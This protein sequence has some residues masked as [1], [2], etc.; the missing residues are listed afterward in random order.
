MVVVGETILTS[1]RRAPRG[2]M[3]EVSG[4]DLG[5]GKGEDTGHLSL[6]DKLSP[7]LWPRPGAWEAGLGG[8]GRLQSAVRGQR[9]KSE[10]GSWAGAGQAHSLAP[11][12]KGNGCWVLRKNEVGS[13]FGLKT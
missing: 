13:E 3:V 10:A 5:K 9:N 2:Q 12:A 6:P 8:G 4:S 1:E 11:G 7:G